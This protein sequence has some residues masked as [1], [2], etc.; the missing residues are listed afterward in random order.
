MR[1]GNLRATA[2]SQSLKDFRSFEGRWRS[3]CPLNS[4]IAIFYGVL[5]PVSFRDPNDLKW[6]SDNLPDPSNVHPDVRPRYARLAAGAFGELLADEQ[7]THVQFVAKL[8]PFM[9]INPTN[10]T[11]SR[12]QAF[13]CN[14]ETNG[15]QAP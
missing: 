8:L 14:C 11:N 3:E 9:L 5:R 10:I 4:K 7:P 13:N 6:L 1:T 2:R 12:T 15:L